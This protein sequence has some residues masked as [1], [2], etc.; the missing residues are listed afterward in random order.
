MVKIF[1]I[2]VITPMC[3]K[4]GRHIKNIFKNECIKEQF[5][6]IKKYIIRTFCKIINKLN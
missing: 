2:G 6:Q 3:F 1:L 5:R 4:L